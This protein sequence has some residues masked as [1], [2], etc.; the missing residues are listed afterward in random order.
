[1][2]S[3]LGNADGR[4]YSRL[5]DRAEADEM[6][7]DEAHARRVYEESIRPILDRGH[8]MAAKDVAP[9]ARM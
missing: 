4:A 2:V 7:V 3:A 5:L 8:R 6:N 9:K 1:M